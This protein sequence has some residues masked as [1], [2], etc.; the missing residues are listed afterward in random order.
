MNDD[1]PDKLS[2]GASPP[3]FCPAGIHLSDGGNPP[4][5]GKTAGEN[6]L[7]GPPLWTSKGAGGVQGS[8]TPRVWL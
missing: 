5:A 2:E 6:V 1:Q 4:T 3:S 7:W 8:Q